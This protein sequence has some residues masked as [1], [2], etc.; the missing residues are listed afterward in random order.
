MRDFYSEACTLA[1]EEV[2]DWSIFDNDND[3]KIDFIFFIYAGGGQ[4][5]PKVNDPNVIWPKENASDF[6]I[7]FYGKRSLVVSDVAVSL[8]KVI[9]ME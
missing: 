7:T 6:T 8:Q 5:D 1:S 2:T 3:N 4:N 9:L